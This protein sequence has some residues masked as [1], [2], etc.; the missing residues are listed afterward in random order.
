M[1]G[2]GTNLNY[3]ATSPN[4]VLC[5]PS[6][7][8]PHPA[9]DAIAR[10]ESGLAVFE[11]IR[12]R[13]H[14]HAVT[15]CAFDLLEVDAEDLRREPIEERSRVLKKLVHNSHPGIPPLNRHFAVAAAL[16]YKRACALSGEGVVSKR[17]ASPHRSGRVNQWL[18]INNLIAPAVKREAEKDWGR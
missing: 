11:M 16:V 6:K 5:K 18:R 8:T 15:L 1:A 17:R 13:Q 10:D 3:T 14:D 4:D 2:V 12:W 7:E 9:R